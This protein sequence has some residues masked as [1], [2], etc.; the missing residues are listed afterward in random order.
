ML[1]LIRNSLESFAQI[2]FEFW[3]RDKYLDA[4]QMRG[5]SEIFGVGYLESLESFVQRQEFCPRDERGVFCERKERSA[6]KYSGG[7]HN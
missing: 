2:Q 4:D 7:W 3:L 5:K 1:S 6:N